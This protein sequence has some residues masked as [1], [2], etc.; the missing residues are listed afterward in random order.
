M[1][2]DK[3]TEL[4]NEGTLDYCLYQMYGKEEKL[5]GVEIGAGNG[6]RSS[7]LMGMYRNLVLY[8][9][10]LW[11]QEIT[12][13]DPKVSTSE[14]VLLHLYE[15][16]KS[17]IEPFGYQGKIVKGFPWEA[18]YSIMDDTQDFVIFSNHFNGNFKKNFF[19]WVPKVKNGGIICGVKG[20]IEVN[21]IVKDSYPDMLIVNDDGEW[22]FGPIDDEIR[23]WA[24]VQSNREGDWNES[25][26]FES[27]HPDAK[28][29]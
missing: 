20:A 6:F 25:G 16:A 27:S 26:Y 7:S 29:R 21:P 1:D 24:I 28:L 23:E 17:K 5:R 4:F 11:E 14:E 19:L 8:C 15:E 18:S 3:V 13:A 22:I 10:D 2:F 9:I 12:R